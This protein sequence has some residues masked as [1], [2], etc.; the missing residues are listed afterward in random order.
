[1]AQQKDDVAAQLIH[2]SPD[3]LLENPPKALFASA[4]EDHVDLFGQLS[5]VALS[6][7]TE[8][9]VFDPLEDRQSQG[10]YDKE[11]SETIED[12]RFMV[13]NMDTE[14]PQVMKS[15]IIQMFRFIERKKLFL[16]GML[17]LEA[18]A[19]GSSLFVDVEP[20]IINKLEAMHK[21]F[22][23]GV[24]FPK[25]EETGEGGKTM[26]T[27]RFIGRYSSLGKLWPRQEDIS[28]K[29]FVVNLNDV[30]GHVAGIVVANNGVAEFIILADTLTKQEFKIDFIVMRQLLEDFKAKNK[31][32]I[33]WFKWELGLR[34][35][36][37][38]QTFQ[39]IKNDKEIRKVIEDYNKRISK[40]V[41]DYYKDAGVVGTEPQVNL[42]KLSETEK[43]VVAR[44]LQGA[45]ETLNRW[46]KETEKKQ[47]G[48]VQVTE[49]SE[50][51]PVDE[52]SSSDQP[53]EESPF[54]DQPDDQ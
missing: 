20:D 25:I 16:H 24:T 43:K 29:N 45:I 44:D 46:Y 36:A 13:A 22:R 53:D 21:H 9:V 8:M 30:Q 5:V 37:N 6:T 15:R 14:D 48:T 3:I 1:M 31:T 18:N 32:P 7:P 42:A 27:I 35:V 34:A 11:T 10:L 52:T 28:G 38:L 51:Q 40:I 17:E 2:T 50:E 41:M 33:C 23:D 19:F 54:S 4:T 47:G 12:F 26:T 49:E 39:A